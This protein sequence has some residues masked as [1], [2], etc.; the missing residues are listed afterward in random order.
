MN[1]I[2]YPFGSNCPKLYQYKNQ[3]QID[4][5]F[6]DLSLISGTFVVQRFLTREKNNHTL[7]FFFENISAQITA[8]YIVEG[9]F[10]IKTY[11]EFIELL[12][13]SKLIRG[14]DTNSDSLLGFTEFNKIL[15]PKNLNRDW[16]F[17]NLVNRQVIQIPY[18]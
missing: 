10:K 11:A 17:R 15:V 16:L 5:I 2:Y 12:L 13:N 18:L 1:K 6:S 14:Y 9:S 3:Q 4:Y 8:V 7:I